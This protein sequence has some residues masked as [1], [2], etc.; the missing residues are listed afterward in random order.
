MQPAFSISQI[1]GNTSFFIQFWEFF[2]NNTVIR[3]LKAITVSH[4]NIN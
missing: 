4:K 2:A 1:M 3:G